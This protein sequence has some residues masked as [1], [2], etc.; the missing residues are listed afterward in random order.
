MESST[1][2]YLLLLLSDGNLP[3]GSF[4]ASS[5]LES[6]VKHG[7]FSRS[8]NERDATINFIRDSLQSN[9]HSTLPFI[10]HAHGIVTGYLS[11]EG[12]LESAL[13]EIKRVEALY[14][15]MTLNHVTR[16]ASKAQGVALLTLFSKGFAQ[17]SWVTTLQPES[18]KERRPEEVVDAFKT[19]VRRGDTHGHLPTCWAVLTASLGLSLS[20]SQHLH[21]FLHARAVLSA[22]IRL[23]TMG[24]YAAQQLLLHVVRPLVDA[25]LAECQDLRI[26][27]HF[28]KPTNEDDDGPATTWPLGEILAARH[29]LQHSR[30]FNS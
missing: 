7:H 13:D 14:E 16:R 23:N 28:D 10:S 3:T 9:A 1:E 4:V 27:P 8:W 19:M 21:L 12:T 18:A 24:P 20:R 25:T 30:I 6:L 26:P 17:P 2:A 15:S 22:S 29:D 5:G 11:G